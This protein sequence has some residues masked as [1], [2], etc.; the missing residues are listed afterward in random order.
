LEQEGV[1]LRE[2]LPTLTGEGEIIQ[3]KSLILQNL[4][5]Q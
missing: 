1:L 3:Q 4:N 2:G 5:A